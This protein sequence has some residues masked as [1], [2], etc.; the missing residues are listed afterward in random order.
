MN[1]FPDQLC[2]LSK[3]EVR[4]R[5][6]EIGTHHAESVAAA[7]QKGEFPVALWNEIGQSGMLGIASG[8]GCGTT[9]GLPYLAAA[10]EGLTY[11]TMDGGFGISIIVHS[12]LGIGMIESCAPVSVHKRYLD[13]L[14]RGNM[15]LAFAV[16]EQQG[17]TDSL[18]PRTIV[19][20]RADG[21]FVLNGAKW[22]ITNAPIADVILATARNTETGRITEV[23]VDR[24]ANGVSTSPQFKIAGARTSPV[25]EIVFTDVV[26]QSDQVFPPIVQGKNMLPHILSREKVV[27]AIGSTGIMDRVVDECLNYSRHRKTGERAIIG[28]QH[29]QRRLTDLQLA[30]ET[31]RALGHQTM[32]KLI[33]EEDVV[34]E[35]ATLKL[36]M[37]QTAFRAATEAILAMGSAGLA[38]ESRMPMAL[39]DAL[40][41]MIGGG[42]EEAQ[43]NIMIGEMVR[44]RNRKR[45][46]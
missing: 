34:L 44:R 6:S 26:L 20:R 9:T 42:T 4:S 31:T 15:I 23:I 8:K 36:H 21:S 33:Q 3:D 35:A 7:W 10:L 28:F 13:D 30:L 37:G 5:F 24:G 46:K 40:S 32:A 22:H 43:R 2:H 12:V 27:G 41:V 45:F 1:S 19:S 38:N 39:M 18:N 25:G 14:A 11:S 16:T 17:G 29:V